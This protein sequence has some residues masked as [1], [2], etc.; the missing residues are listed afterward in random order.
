MKVEFYKHNLGA[1]EKAK[2]A[3][4]LNGLFLTTGQYVKDFEIQF[5]SY[6]GAQHVVGLTSCTAA[7]HLALL[8]LDIG[9]GDEV[10]TTP[11]TFIATANSILYVGAKPIF[12]DV[13]E[14]TG[15][16]DPKKIEAAITKRT[17][18]IIPVHL[19]GQMCDMKA[20]KSLAQKYDLKIIEDCAHCVE[21]QR[22]GV[23]PGQ[24]GDIACFSFYAT[25]NLTCGE[26]GALSTNNPVIAEKVL[27]LRQ[28]GMSKSAADRYVS[29]YQHWD[30][31]ELGWKYNMSNIQAALLIPQIGRIEDRWQERELLYKEYIKVFDNISGVILPKIFPSAKSAYHLF[32]IRVHAGHRDSL[33]AALNAEG[34]G[35]AVNYRS[36]HL[37]SFYVKKYG[38]KAGDF[39]C[40]ERIGNETISLPF[41]IGLNSQS[42]NDI[43]NVVR[44]FLERE[45][46]QQHIAG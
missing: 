15:L 21:G 11:M 2:M 7:L 23:R 8:A 34:I 44:G 20:I 3:E 9:E 29:V 6:L 27:M 4:C 26:G 41:W 31:M 46:I 19:Y 5:A 24:L 42:I 45:E 28:H 10:I 17:K 14:A 25:K 1:A 33:L 43:G 37:L 38:F 22:D 35:C 16:I 40:S 12:V 13:E 32:T 36:V 30:M 18:A 39:L